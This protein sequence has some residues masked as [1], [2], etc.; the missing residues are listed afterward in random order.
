MGSKNLGSVKEERARMKKNHI[1]PN[2]KEDYFLSD[3]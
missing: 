3:A 1:F 2:E